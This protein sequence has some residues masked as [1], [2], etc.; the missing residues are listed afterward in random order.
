V[1]D[2]RRRALTPTVVSDSIA[3]SGRSYDELEYGEVKISGVE[4]SISWI[5]VRLSA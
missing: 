3:L 4:R 5:V 2:A 1:V